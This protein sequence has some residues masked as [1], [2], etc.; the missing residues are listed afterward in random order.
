MRCK[1]ALID[2]MN[3]LLGH[4]RV[5]EWNYDVCFVDAHMMDT[6]DDM[7]YSKLIAAS[8]RVPYI[9]S[10]RARKMTAKNRDCTSFGCTLK[11]T[12]SSEEDSGHCEHWSPKCIQFVGEGHPPQAG[13][14]RAFVRHGHKPLPYH[15]TVLYWKGRVLLDKLNNPHLE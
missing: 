14:I 3:V 1:A 5:L 7:I 10:T 8:Y 13:V 11:E 15:L 4:W 2:T 6:A 12:G 9:R